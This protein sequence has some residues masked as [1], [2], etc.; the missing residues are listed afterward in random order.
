MPIE[1]VDTKAFKEAEDRSHLGLRKAF[2]GVRKAVNVETRTVDFVISTGAV[3]RDGD[4]IDPKGFNLE[5]FRKNPVVLFAHD[6][7]QPPIGKAVD[8]RS[9]DQALESRAEFATREVL[10]F[11][12]TIFQLIAND[13]LNATS[14]GLIPKEFEFSDDEN[15]G[16]MAMDITR[17]DLLEFSVVPVPSN[18][19]ALIQ[20]RAKGIDTQPLL[21]WAEQVLDEQAPQA[22]EAQ[23]VW[24]HLR[25]TQG[26]VL[27]LGRQ[28]DLAQKN[29]EHAK[30]G[31]SPD[32]TEPEASGEPDASATGL[33]EGASISGG[34]ERQFLETRRFSS[35]EIKQAYSYAEAAPHV[36]KP[37]VP[38]EG[39]EPGQTAVQTV[40]F[41][42]DTWT[43]SQAESW[44]RDN[45]F[46]TDG[47]D[48]EDERLRF[49][50][51]NPD[52]CAEDSFE[53]LTENLPDGVQLVTCEGKSAAVTGA[54]TRESDEARQARLRGMALR[55]RQAK[56]LL[57]A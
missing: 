24:Q 1:F 29:L 51:F 42:K 31:E 22:K 57:T 50:Q 7:R 17:S 47:F 18:P 30:Q 38:A 56:V 53:T 28:L 46:R 12:D 19:E 10:P 44:L 34:E 41:A 4:T 40:T 6:Q 3:D 14:V 33:V 23:D 9:T 48:E 27:S 20:A 52:A 45:D 21:T 15:R 54:S 8:I 16:F 11:A 55:A 26:L 2:S 25:K 36:T 35:H 49:R 32:T 37:P 43:R 13:F 39:P 5:G